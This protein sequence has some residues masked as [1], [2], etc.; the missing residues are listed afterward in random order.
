M[1]QITRTSGF[2][3]G[4]EIS[5]QQKQLSLGLAPGCDIRFD[6]TWDK[7]VDP[8]H[9]KISYLQGKVSYQ[10]SGK[11]GTFID[12]RSVENEVIEPG[13]VLQFGKGGPTIRIDYDPAAAPEGSPP[14]VP[15]KKQSAPSTAPLPHPDQPQ[16]SRGIPPWAV[17]FA[18]LCLAI[19]AGLAWWIAQEKE[20][21]ETTPQPISEMPP[22]EPA[23]ASRP[24]EPEG[25]DQMRMAARLNEKAV[26]LVCVIVPADK[27]QRRIP[28]A[29]AWALEPQVFVTNAHVAVDVEKI[30]EAGGEAFIAP[31]KTAHKQIRVIDVR[32]HPDYGRKIPDSDGKLPPIP[33][34]DV[35]ILKT[36]TPVTETLQLADEVEL[37]GLDSG[38]RVAYLGFP[39]EGMAG[40][41]VNTREPVANM[42]SGIITS[43]TTFWQAHGS[44]GERYLINHNLGLAGG[45]SGSPL[46]NEQGKVIGILSAGN[47]AGQVN[48]KTG[49]MSRTPSAV[50]INFA[51]RI[52][53]LRDIWRSSYQ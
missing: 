21:Q 50:M 28:L 40:G 53:I 5:F 30:I 20:A 44:P 23:P 27:D 11:G 47:M 29:T 4:K 2:E 12:G 8:V 6:P 48:L 36:D 41:G 46:F 33:I 43:V 1:I 3:R 51:Q 37:K 22:V 26:G 45:A 14:P 38:I 9:G 13:T 35:A 15:E 42:Q 32:M 18:L 25:G 49:E 34:Y 19:A 24:A 39:M 31:N 17:G 52:D 16:R 7:M 10:N